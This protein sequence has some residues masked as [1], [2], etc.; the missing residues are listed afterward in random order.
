MDIIGSESQGVNE[1]K[2]EDDRKV[3]CKKFPWSYACNHYMQM[4]CGC[5]Y[6]VYPVA[7]IQNDFQ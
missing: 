4:T 6:S 5:F 1:I 2:K 7:N 3:K